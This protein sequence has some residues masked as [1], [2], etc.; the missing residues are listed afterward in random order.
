MN[1]FVLFRVIRLSFF[2]R[3]FRVTHD[4]DK[5]KDLEEAE[6]ENA[7]PLNFLL[8]I[9]AIP[10]PPLLLLLVLDLELDGRKWKEG[11][12]PLPLDL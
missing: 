10:P 5:G 8:T 4:V 1:K 3:F 9:R 12:P 11:H 7:T 6:D 2:C